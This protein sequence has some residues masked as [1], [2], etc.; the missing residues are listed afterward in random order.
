MS[1]EQW[2]AVLITLPYFGIFLLVCAVMAWVE[3]IDRRRFSTERR[4]MKKCTIC[5]GPNKPER[6]AI[7]YTH[8]TRTSCVNTW[9]QRRIADSDLSLVNVHKQGPMWM[10]KDE[11]P[12]NSMRRDDGR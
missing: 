8:C 1:A 5:G 3:R 12:G 10:H 9:R 4:T 6:H 2:H 7:G 11:V